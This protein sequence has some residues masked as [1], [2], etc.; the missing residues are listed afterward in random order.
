MKI[1]NIFKP[2]ELP[3]A[4]PYIPER[5]KKIEGFNE[6]VQTW[7]NNSQKLWKKKLSTNKA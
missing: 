7:H 4:K 2:R 1:F 6:A 5:D 3:E